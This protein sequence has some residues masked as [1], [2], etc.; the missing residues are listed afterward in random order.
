MSWT[1]LGGHIRYYDPNEPELPDIGESN[2][3]PYSR[4][5]AT[6]FHRKNDICMFGG[7]FRVTNPLSPDGKIFFKKLRKIWKIFKASFR[8]FFEFS[9]IE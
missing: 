3:L 9:D 6:T 4:F 1:F 7:I 8:I 2:V 5:S